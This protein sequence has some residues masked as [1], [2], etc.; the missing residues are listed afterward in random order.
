MD[1]TERR[2]C[3]RVALNAIEDGRPGDAEPACRSLLQHDP[4]DV[5]ALLFL[6]LLLGV[7]GKADVAAPILNRVA[8]ER[9]RHAHPCR[10]VAQMLARQQQTTRIAPLYRA[11]LRLTPHDTRLCYAFADFLIA[12][13]EPEVAVALLEPIVRANPTHAA[14]H[15]QFGQALAEAGQ[16]AA[17]AGHYRQAIAI[18][19]A[20]AAFWANLGMMLKVEGRFDAALDAYAEALARSPEDTQIRVNRAVACLHAGR[21]V[22]AWQDQAWRLTPSGGTALA[23]ERQLPPLSRVPDLHG[24]T[25]LVVQEEGLGDTLQFMRYLPLLAARGAH[26]VVAVPPALTRIMHRVVGVAEVPN[27]AAPIPPHD[28]HCSFNGLLRAFDTTLDSIPADIP[29]LTAEPKLV[30][31]WARNLPDTDTLRVG[32]VWAGQARP[33]LP[34]FTNLDRRRSMHLATLA[35]LSAITG[36]SFVSL[37]KGPAGAEAHAPH[38]AI[39]LLD[40]MDQAHDFADTA[41]II[42]NLDLVVSVDT[43]VVHLAGAMGKPVFLLDRYDN[44]WRWLSGREDSPWYPSLRIF[45]QQRSGDWGPVIGRV[46][47]ALGAMVAARAGQANGLRHAA[48]APAARSTSLMNSLL[49]SV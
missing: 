18:D 17:A 6:G 28:F 35:P 29:Y 33:W 2:R 23:P 39:T 24:R 20:P 49:A 10:D 40:P 11:C 16:F 25:V 43:S 31:A 42:A 3:L 21:L 32:L 30:D 36:I 37:Q 9:P 7:Q 12:N 46:V 5:E 44:C 22:E 38:T 4:E 1:A 19:P 45:R 27:G 14:A 8:L 13:G 26:V 47:T 41:A 48:S 15:Y 34:G